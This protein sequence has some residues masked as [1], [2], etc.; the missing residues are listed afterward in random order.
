MI[1]E[2][3]KA[4]EV[5]SGLI[6]EQSDFRL[7]EEGIDRLPA[8][9]SNSLRICFKRVLTL[10]EAVEYTGLKK[11]CLYKLTHTRSIP[12][13]KPNGKNIFFD[14]IELEEWM[15]SGPVAT[16]DELNAHVKAYCRKNK[17]VG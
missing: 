12:H 2:N 9:A 11:S 14:R 4:S 3:N 8:G 15:M 5:E 1:T 6:E 13:S 17:R 7:S 10:E 16:E